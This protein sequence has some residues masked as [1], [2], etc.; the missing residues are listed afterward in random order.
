MKFFDKP[1][2]P[3]ELERLD[4]MRLEIVLV[5]NALNPPCQHR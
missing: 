5:P 4:Q 1:F 2:V 3:A